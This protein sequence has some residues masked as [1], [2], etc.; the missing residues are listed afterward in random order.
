VEYWSNGVVERWSGGKPGCCRERRLVWGMKRYFF[1]NAQGLLVSVF[2]GVDRIRFVDDQR[3]SPRTGFPF[4]F[5]SFD[6]AQKAVLELKGLAIENFEIIFAELVC[7]AISMVTG[8]TLSER[9]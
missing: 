3:F 6:Q 4:V 1:T 5:Q 2:S 7:L 8:N 9:A